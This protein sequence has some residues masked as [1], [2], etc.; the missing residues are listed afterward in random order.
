M[1]A[2]TSLAVTPPLDVSAIT[3]LITY[4]STQPP[5]SLL[6]GAPQA[7]PHPV[8]AHPRASGAKLVEPQSG[9]PTLP[10]CQA[11]CGKQLVSELRKGLRKVK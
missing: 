5:L 9:S 6:P 3:F 11:L 8:S 1:W 7:P 4:N 2:M 10:R